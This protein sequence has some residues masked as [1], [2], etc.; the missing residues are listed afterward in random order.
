MGNGLKKLKLSTKIF[1]LTAV[2]LAVAAILGVVSSINMFSAGKTSAFIAKEIVPSIGISVPMLATI[3]DFALNFSVYSYTGSTEYSDNIRKNIAEL[4]IEFENARALLRTAS[5]LPTFENSVRTLEPRLRSLKVN[6]DSMFV[7]G[8]KMSEQ[9]N[10]FMDLTGEILENLVA[11][12]GIMD[13]DTQGQSSSQDKS[14]LL[15]ILRVNI[16][17]AIAAN[18][19]IKT[20]DTIGG[21]ELFGNVSDLTLCHKLHNSPT[22]SGAFR[23]GVGGVIA[24]RIEQISTLNEFMKL[25]VQRN[26]V[27]SVVQQELNEFV[28][29]VDVLI[30]ATKTTATNET[31]AAQTSLNR[32]VVVTNSLL[33][34]AIIFGI[35]F[36]TVI[37]RSIVNPITSA[38]DEL[39][40]SG[41]Q[42]DMAAQEIANTASGMASGASEQA[43]SLEEISSSLNEITSMTKQTSDNVRTA[44][45]LVDDSVQK[46]K[47]SQN[48]ARRLREAVA[49]IQKSSNDTAKILKDIDDIAFQTNLLALNAAVEA[50]RAGEAGKGFAVVA[51]EVRN[52]AQRSA[53]SAKKTATLIE[54][55]QS[56]STNGVSLA[57]ETAAAIEK[58]AESS[59][60]IAVI[61]HEI[62]SAANEQSKGISQVNQAIGN[63]DSVTQANASGS[64]ELAA[65]SEELS[66]QTVSMNRSVGELIKIVKGEDAY[67]NIV[68]GIGIKTNRLDIKKPKM[69]IPF[70]DDKCGNY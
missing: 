66:S 26:A 55:S 37:T 60:K 30:Q 20:V 25:Q 40:G 39:S 67:T 28:S 48:A 61:I 59:N 38:I 47:D 24:K 17:R 33:I 27:A 22:L 54:S 19:Y 69:L 3:D 62:T 44:E 2:L 9:Q 63:M 52:L 16:G 64:E 4:E 49:E 58:I 23:D 45:A 56:S 15:N 51:E 50:A 43:A 7:L 11:F 41:N 1:V 42:V 5:N 35:I 36:A 70:D 31:N 8:A 34:L 57:E 18:A 29:G 46:A 65:S 32:S 21:A 14:L 6:A 53:E 13:A 10:K 68:S 12:N